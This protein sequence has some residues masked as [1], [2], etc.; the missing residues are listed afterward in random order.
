MNKEPEE[1]RSRG[2]IAKRV[3]I[4]LAA[5]IGTVFLLGASLAGC[6][7]YV[8]E[9]RLTERQTDTSPDGQYAVQYQNIGEPDWPF[10]NAHIKVTVR[11]GGKVIA[12]FKE[13]VADDGGGGQVKTVWNTHEV[14]VILDGDEQE[15]SYHYIPL[16]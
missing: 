5:V 13:D 1:G 6:F 3:A 14:I 9:Y 7:I 4:V 11:R 10:G 15:P 2:K 12:S 8:T 16:D